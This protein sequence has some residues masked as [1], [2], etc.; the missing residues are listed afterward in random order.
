M[1]IKSVQ[2]PA[3]GRKADVMLVQ[4]NNQ[5]IGRVKRYCKKHEVRYSEFA[6]VSGIPLYRFYDLIHNNGKTLVTDEDLDKIDRAMK[7]GDFSHIS[8][9][10]EAYG[11]YL[12]SVSR[13]C[14]VTVEELA[15]LSG[16]SPASLYQ[17][18]RGSSCPSEPTIKKLESAIGKTMKRPSEVTKEDSVSVSVP[19]AETPADSVVQENSA[20]SP[21][22]EKAEAAV[23]NVSVSNAV[24]VQGSGEDTGKPSPARE[25]DN[26]LPVSPVSASVSVSIPADDILEDHTGLMDRFRKAFCE[27]KS[28]Q[29]A[30]NAPTVYELERRANRKDAVLIDNLSRLVSLKEA[31]IYAG[32]P[33][34]YL[35]RPSSE[36]DGIR[37]YYALKLAEFAHVTIDE[38]LQ[39]KQMDSMLAERDATKKRALELEKQMRELQRQMEQVTQKAED[40]DGKILQVS[41]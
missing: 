29:G 24:S 34:D 15:Q 17:F 19:A 37:L 22:D 23:D 28:A 11:A 2:K 7:H 18:C 9:P 33:E 3:S 5:T 1:S 14:D 41:G 27:D 21:A 36:R 31:A 20:V 38:L 25:S 40:L 10:Y 16:V 35:T 12:Q 30:S 26:A 6:A 4:R 13:E 39:D 32:L 8:Y